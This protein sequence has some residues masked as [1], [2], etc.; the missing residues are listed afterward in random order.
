MY[1]MLVSSISFVY[2]IAHLIISSTLFNLKKH[3]LKENIQGWK[4]AC[5]HPSFFLVAFHKLSS[6]HPY[7]HPLYEIIVFI[8]ILYK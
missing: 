2:F 1:Y 4:F 6:P 7:S 5:F 8:V 3:S